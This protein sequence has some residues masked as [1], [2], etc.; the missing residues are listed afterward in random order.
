MRTRRISMNAKLVVLYLLASAFTLGCSDGRSQ[1]SSA[2]P[3]QKKSQPSIKMV[4]EITH[5]DVNAHVQGI[6]ARSEACLTALAQ[7]ENKTF[8]PREVIS[9]ADARLIGT[10][11]VEEYFQGDQYARFETTV[12]ISEFDSERDSKCRYDLNEK[13]F[14]GTIVK[15]CKTLV[16]GTDKKIVESVLPSDVCGM[17]GKTL[18]TPFLSD[19]KAKIA[20]HECTYVK[21][22][23]DDP[24]KCLLSAHPVYAVPG[25][26]GVEVH[27]MDDLDAGKNSKFKLNATEVV[28]E[29]EIG[30]PIA[31]GK[32]EIPA[33]AASFS[34]EKVE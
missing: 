30:K 20:G 31:T 18:K 32:F 3:A 29:I 8:N 10:G 4:K 23:A 25:T 17:V 16:W 24:A 19:R 14:V 1:A 12:A 28:K 11:T 13:S 5:F 34:R 6:R 15:G 7:K 22:L 9:E 2:A 33:Y 27:L 21:T 26:T